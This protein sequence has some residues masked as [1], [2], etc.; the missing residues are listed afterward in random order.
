[1]PTMEHSEEKVED[2]Y[3]T[4]QLLDDETKGNDYAI[5]MGDFN[6]V[7]AEGKED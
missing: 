7:V 5:V 2:M 1:M 3:E 6:V 4:E